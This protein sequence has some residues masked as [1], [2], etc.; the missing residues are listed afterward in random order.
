M[1][2]YST[3]QLI[4]KESLFYHSSKSETKNSG[5]EKQKTKSKKVIA[6]SFPSKDNNEQL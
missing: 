2:Y 6:T 4:A 3:H 5:N 1:H